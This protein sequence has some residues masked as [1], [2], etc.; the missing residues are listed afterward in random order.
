LFQILG[1][2]PTTSHFCWKWCT[3]HADWIN[4]FVCWWKNI[5]LI[6]HVPHDMIYQLIFHFLIGLFVQKL[7][8]VVQPNSFWCKNNQLMASKANISTSSTFIKTVL[9]LILIAVSVSYVF[10]WYPI[11][12]F[13]SSCVQYHLLSK[14]SWV[15]VEKIEKSDYKTSETL[16]VQNVWVLSCFC[17]MMWTE[18]VGLLVFNKFLKEFLLFYY[19]EMLFLLVSKKFSPC[20]YMPKTFLKTTKNG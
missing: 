12:C 10:I 4:L 14:I 16:Q 8:D 1:S 9:I 18:M 2:L 13:Y 5:I 7:L 20:K 6:D 3:N 15:I 19:F 17:K 11:L